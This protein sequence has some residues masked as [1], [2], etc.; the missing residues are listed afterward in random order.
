MGKVSIAHILKGQKIYPKWLS[1]WR[2][3][4]ST[5]RRKLP[6][7]KRK[8]TPVCPWNFLYLWI[9]YNIIKRIIHSKKASS[10]GEGK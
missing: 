6:Y 3:K 4:I 10:K 8:N 1:G 5:Q 9:K 2:K 7:H